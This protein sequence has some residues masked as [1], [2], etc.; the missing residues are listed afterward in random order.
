MRKRRLRQALVVAALGVITALLLLRTERAGELVCSQLRARLPAALD[1][2]VAIGRCEIDPLTAAIEVHRVAVIDPTSRELVLTTDRARVSLRGLFL[3]GVALQDVELLRPEIRVDLTARSPAALGPASPRTCPLEALKRIRV[4]RLRIDEARVHV[5]AP[6]RELRLEGVAVHASM[7]RRDAELTVD[8]RSGAL[9]L[10]ARDLHLGKLTLEGTLD[11]SASQLDLQRAELNVEGVSLALS[12]QVDGLC[13]PVPQL[14]A[15]GQVYLPL[16]VLERLGAPLPP[17]VSGQ[18]WARVAVN[19]RLDEPTVRAEVQASQLA[20]GIYAPGDFAAKVVWSGKRVVLEDFSAQSGG[21]ELQVNG[22]LQLVE[23]WPVKAR[24]ETHDASFARVMARCSVPGAWVEFPASVKGEVTGHLLPAPALSGDMEFE[25]GR[26]VL[27][28]RAFDAP[29]AAGQD[30]LTFSRAAGTFRFGVSAE[31]VT[32]DDIALRV[33]A[34]GASRVTGRVRLHYD[35]TKGLDIAASSENIDLSDFGSIAELPWAGVGSLQAAISGPYQHIGVAAQATLRDFKLAGYSLGVVQSPIKLDGTV[36]SFPTVVA[37]KGQS[38]YFG[39]VSLDFLPAG[40]QVRSTVQLPDGRVEDM[41]DLLADLSPLLENLQ[42]GVLTGRLSA[43]AAVDSPARELMGVIAARVHD[44]EYLGRQLGASE[45]VTHFD[46]GEA[47]VLDPLQFNGP[48]GRLTA[49]G[50][51]DFAGPLAFELALEGGSVAELVDPKGSAGVPV[52]GSFAAHARV[53]GDT[54]TVLVNGSLTSPEVSWKGRRLGPTHL[55]GHLTGRDFRA[56]GALFPGLTGTLAISVRNE[57]PYEAAVAVDLGDLSPFLPQELSAKVKATVKANGPLRQWRQSRAK[58]DLELLTVARGE[59]SIS[60]EGPVLLEYEAGAYQ[61]S[62][63]SMKGPTTELT[64]AGTWGPSLVNLQTRGSVDLRL[65]STFTP[66]IERAQG[67]VDFTAAFSGPARAPVLAGTA[68]ISDVRFAVRGQDLQMR[69]LSGRADFSES[70]VLFQDI[71]GFLN[72]GRLRARGDVRLDHLSLRGVELHADL[73]DV[74]IQPWPD[75][76]ATISGGLMMSSRAAGLWLL[77]GALD[78]Q[79]FR[80]T[81]PLTLAGLLA[82]A[83]KG[84]PSDEQPEEWLKLDVDIGSAGDVRIENNLA[85]ARLIG[86]LKLTGTNVRPLLIGAVEAGEGA[87]AFFGG[88]TFFL[89]RGLLQFNGQSPNFDLSAQARVRDYLVSV[90]AFGRLDDPK[91]NFSSEPTLPETDILSLLTLGVT[92]RERDQVSGESGAGWAAG[93]ILSASGLDQVVQ[94]FLAQDLGLK[95]Q[96]LRLTTSFNE[97][98]GNVEPAVA[99]DYKALSDNLR[100]GITKPVTGRSVKAEAEY[101][102]GRQVS[103]RAQWD[104]QNQNTVYGNPG[105]DLRFRFEWE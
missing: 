78:V 42:D 24:I 41:V 39:D 81:Q 83:K 102:F 44:V 79:K 85:R 23:G 70:R 32:F 22:E 12:G 13:E 94:R 77:Q 4:N 61:V 103:A 99:L 72:D 54:E 34:E 58:A 28:A 66:S 82:N 75:L 90:K 96:Q 105:V 51:W 98:T 43:L 19:G 17:P 18:V 69:S 3:G 37:Q 91:V 31:A 7:G 53:G 68:E 38:Q 30:I 59:T 87:Q 6:D 100:V 74:T 93:A 63:L 50:R 27:A 9:R 62:S 64:A 89:S 80:Y 29:R 49:E 55:E 25:T 40:L 26:F 2:E 14:A 104:D 48:L 73:E 35:P 56:A 67:R 92:S 97:V 21:G 15:R 5:V 57:W 46:H 84:L 16:E 60:N 95:D 8:A 33:G 88:N 71:Q 101:R 11:Q 76:P 1:A 47:L 20:I 52:A 45:I 36:L 65:L 86:K 10:G